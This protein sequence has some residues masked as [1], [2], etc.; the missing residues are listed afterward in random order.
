MGITPNPYESLDEAVERLQALTEEAVGLAAEI[1]RRTQ[2]HGLQVRR[3][4]LACLQN[5]DTPCEAAEIAK[6]IWEGGVTTTSDFHTFFNT[7]KLTLSN[8]SAN[9]EIHKKWGAGYLFGTRPPP[10]PSRL[11]PP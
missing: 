8:L 3:A 4:I 2:Y 6:E 7:V 5:R 10:N 9:G 11:P 1:K